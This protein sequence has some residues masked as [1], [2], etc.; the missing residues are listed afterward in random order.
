MPVPSL[1]S[2]GDTQM[3]LCPHCG[4]TIGQ[5]IPY[6]TKDPNSKMAKVRVIPLGESHFF[7]APTMAERGRWQ[8]SAASITKMHKSIR[9]TTRTVTRG[10]VKGLEIWRIA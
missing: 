7:P 3:L 10:G 5:A 1:V 9:F 2:P 8:A 6:R 4:G